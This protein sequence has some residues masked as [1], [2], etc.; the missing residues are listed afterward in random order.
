MAIADA[1][2]ALANLSARRLRTP[3]ALDPITSAEANHAMLRDEIARNLAKQSRTFQTGA[4]AADL[5]G[6]ENDPWVGVVARKAVDD[7][8]KNY[9]ADVRYK[10]PEATAQRNDA[11]AAKLAVAKAP[12]EAQ[13]SGALATEREKNKGL[14]DVLTAKNQ[15]NLDLIKQAQAAGGTGT[16]SDNGAGDT[17]FQVSIGPNGPSLKPKTIPQTVQAQIDAASAGLQQIPA[18]RQILDTLVSKGMIGPFVSRAESAGVTTGLDP[19][20]EALHVVPSGGSR[21]FN[22]FKSQLALVKSNLGKVHFGNRA[23]AAIGAK[24]DELL[25]PNQSPEALRGG[26]DTA[27]RW[28]THYAHAKNSAEED[29][30]NAELGITG[31]PY[32]RNANDDDLGAEWGAR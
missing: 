27:E 13:A 20:L 19:L 3:D 1:L 30:A 14:M 9:E 18:T 29:A 23:S 28:L 11:L 32:D 12:A 8:Q 10:S 17:Q 21:A 16:I 6:D 2:E 22:N 15:S 4:T 31:L 7:A 24:F 5:G 25:N 26:L